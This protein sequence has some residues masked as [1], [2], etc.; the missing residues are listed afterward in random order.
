MTT[1]LGVAKRPASR[2]GPGV[3]EQGRLA[4][5]RLT[6]STEVRV[7][8]VIVLLG[9]VLRFTNLGTQSLWTDETFTARYVHGTINEMLLDLPGSDGNPPLYYL[10]EWLFTHVFGQSDAGLRVLSALAGTAT[11]PVFYALG[12]R[13]ASRRAGLIAAGLGA[14]QPMLWW[15]SQ[16]GR[17]YAFF[18]LLVALGLLAFVVALSERSTWALALWVLCGTLMLITQYFAAVL[19]APQA[20]WLLATWPRR[21]REVLLALAAYGVVALGLAINFAAASHQEQSLLR[22][23]VGPGARVLV[24]Q[25]LASPSPPATL[26]W[27]GALVLV[28]VGAGL[29]LVTT[30]PPQRRFALVL[31]S[32]VAWDLGVPVILALAGKEALITRYLMGLLVPLLVLMGIGFASPRLPRVGAAAATLLAVLWLAT[33][34]LVFADPGLQ[35]IDTKAAVRSL[36]SPRFDRVVL[37]PGGY[38]FDYTVPRYLVHA[39]QFGGSALPVQEVDVLIP[40]VEHIQ[41]SCLEG[42]TC[43]LF[44][45][46]ERLDPPA[47]GFRFV[48]AKEV[49][50]FTVMR[51]RAGRARLLKLNDVYASGP[52]APQAP[53]DAFY[54]S[55]Q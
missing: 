49:D 55:V 19:L 33:V 54:Q 43:Q 39:R 51:W 40:H 52:S 11:L 6:Q 13:M 4:L 36:G 16:E 18:T 37:S 34:C 21:R 3:V 10:V 26:L 47:R 53:P 30:S 23:P 28:L 15:Y 48:G 35:R 17:A 27:V 9:A 12:S 50:P 1:G 44:S 24:P 2:P 29:A 41:P 32:L 22:L 5:S 46:R 7:L 8:M 42:Q 20:L 45:T 14:V 25:L 38:L 31:A